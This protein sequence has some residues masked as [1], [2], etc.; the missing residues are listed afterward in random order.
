V[1]A[2]GFLILGGGLYPQPGVASRYHA[3]EM[4]L[5][6]RAQ[7]HLNGETAEALSFDAELPAGSRPAIPSNQ[8]GD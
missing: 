4:L 7:R 1:L 8:S 3:A 6:L 2:L 5:Q